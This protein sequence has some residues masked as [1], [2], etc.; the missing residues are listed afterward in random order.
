VPQLSGFALPWSVVAAA[1]VYFL[2]GYL[3]I[4]GCYAAAGAAM[5]SPQEA[6]ML[7]GPVSFLSVLPL[8]LLGVIIGQPNGA[9]ATAFSLIPFTAPMAMLMRLSLADVPAWQVATSLV[10][11]ALAA[12]G[13]IWLA[14]RVMRL[15]MLR[16]GKR[17]NL[18]EV[19][20]R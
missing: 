9:V 11:L 20:G 2:L 10:I 4:A 12:A 16:Y 19:W 3:L 8:M 6:G 17:L 18:R 15:G 14:A 7:L 13:A 1:M 5:A